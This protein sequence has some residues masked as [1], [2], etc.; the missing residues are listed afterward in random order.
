MNLLSESSASSSSASTSDFKESSANRTIVLAC[1]A[2]IP[3]SHENLKIIV[4]KLKIN[5]FSHP[6]KI[7]SDFKLINMMNGLQSG[8]STY[9]CPYGKCK[10]PN[11]TSGWIKG[12]DRTVKGTTLDNENYKVNGKEIRNNCKFYFNVEKEPLVKPNSD[13]KIVDLYPPPPLHLIRLGALN[14]VYGE[15]SEKIDLNE[16]EQSIGIIKSGYHSG[17]FEGNECAKILK[18]FDKLETIVMESDKELEPFLKVIWFTKLLDEQVNKSEYEEE[19]HEVIEGF[20]DAYGILTEKFNVSVTNKVHVIVDHLSDYLSSNKTTLRKT[21]DQT[22]ECTHS[23]LDQYL[24]ERNY[25]R[26]NLNGKAFGER[27]LKGI[28]AWNSYSIGNS[29]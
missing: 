20:S 13:E 17:V 18:N 14:K 4:D 8:S 19:V 21:T 11:K 3:E 9:P 22:I 25:F 15:L 26:K 6:F 2:G 28:L 24:K 29:Q 16:F 10:K 27:L 1:V 23:K 7:V 12:E 5:D